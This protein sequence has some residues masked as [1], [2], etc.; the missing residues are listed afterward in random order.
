MGQ[1]DPL[2]AWQREG[3]EMFSQ[4]ID[5]IEDDYVRYVM[6]VELI[7]DVAEDE[8]AKASYLAAEDPLEN[9]PAVLAAVG[10][11]ERPASLAT[12]PGS[13]TPVVRPSAPEPFLAGRAGAEP[14]VIE[15]D[16]E[17][18]QP[19]V[20]SDRERLGRNDP[21]WCGSNRKFKQCHGR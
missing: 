15:A 8:L 11:S 10:A 3:Y 18:N 5:S 4:L 21:C 6:H 20:R 17:V 2:V 7:P 9:G 16:D 1:Q 14:L 12:P 13:S 19:V